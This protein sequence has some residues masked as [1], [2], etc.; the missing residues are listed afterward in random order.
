MHLHSQ[1]EKLASKVHKLPEAVTHFNGQA[2]T[3]LESLPSIF[4]RAGLYRKDRDN[5]L[6]SIKFLAQMQM[7]MRAFQPA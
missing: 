3:R 5:E 7:A 6:L 2:D 4:G 1:Y